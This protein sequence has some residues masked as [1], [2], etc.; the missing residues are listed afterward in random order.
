MG[1]KRKLKKPSV[2][3]TLREAKTLKSARQYA[4]QYIEEH[5]A[6]R[7]IDTH[8]SWPEGCGEEFL[9]RYAHEHD[10]DEFQTLGA[11]RHEGLVTFVHIVARTPDDPPEEYDPEFDEHIPSIELDSVNWEEK[12]RSRAPA[13]SS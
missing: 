13:K 11:F 10:V 1:R 8:T 12:Y 3:Q 9:E 7:F 6:A 5:G 2:S 4:A